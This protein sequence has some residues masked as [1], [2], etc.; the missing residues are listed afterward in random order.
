MSCKLPKSTVS[1]DI[2]TRLGAQFKSTDRMSKL[3]CLAT[4]V[5][6]GKLRSETMCPT[7]YNVQ[8][9]LP[10]YRTCCYPLDQCQFFLNVSAIS[11]RVQRYGSTL[12]K[13]CDDKATIF[14][15][16]RKAQDGIGIGYIPAAFSYVTLIRSA[17]SIRS[18]TLEVSGI[19]SW[20]FDVD[21]LA[22]ASP[23]SQATSPWKPDMQ[24]EMPPHQ[25]IWSDWQFHDTMWYL[26]N[27]HI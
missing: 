2:S 5:A 21:S 22:V 18:W 8:Y 19:F 27:L 6:V 16:A 13:P 15:C 24:Q 1:L 10:I 14:F 4:Q 20:P 26:H 11:N 12:A 9:F 7:M 23:K 25:L 17:C 3:S